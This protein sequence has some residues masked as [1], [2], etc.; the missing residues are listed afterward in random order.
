[1]FGTPNNGTPWADVRDMAESLLTYAMNGAVFLKPWMF[2]LNLVGKLVGGTQTSLKQMDIKT[3]IYGLL[4]DGTD[5]GIPYVIVAGNTKEIIPKFEETASLL[6]RLFTRLR[7]RGAYDALDSFL[8]KEANDI[9]VT[10]KSIVDLLNASG[11]KTKPEVFYTACDH[12]NYFNNEKA[13]STL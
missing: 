11:W 10:N 5:P 1:M 6:S 2:V 13:M 3:G 12:L 9:A 4:N 8:F 7:K